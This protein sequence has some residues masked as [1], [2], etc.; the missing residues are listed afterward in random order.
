MDLIAFSF[1]L[2][3]RPSQARAPLKHAEIP[4]QS[5][6]TDHAI[7]VPHRRGPIE[8]R[9]AP[10]CPPSTSYLSASSQARPIEA[11]SAALFRGT[12]RVYPRPHR[13]GPIEARRLISSVPVPM[14]AIR[15]LTGAAPLKPGTAETPFVNLL[16]IRVLTGAAPLKQL[17]L[18]PLQAPSVR[19]PRPHRRGPH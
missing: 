10:P 9:R 5:V 18:L 1:S 15:V 17:G 8:A 11:H 2:Y 3:P 7:R 6:R 4:A 13:R 16:S 12:L 19:Y 14:P